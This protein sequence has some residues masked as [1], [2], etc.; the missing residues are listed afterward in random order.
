M[1]KVLLLA[2]VCV[3]GCDKGDPPVLVPG[4]A[5]RYDEPGSE[6]A[7]LRVPE[8]PEVTALSGVVLK[9]DVLTVIRDPYRDD[10][11]RGPG[12]LVLVGVPVESGRMGYGVLPR[13]S[14]HPVP[15]TP[16]APAAAP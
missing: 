3:V 4:S 11:P 7:K 12:R 2:C 16:T 13:S 8:L 9:G 15:P 5:V 10:Q 14:L 6:M 1:R